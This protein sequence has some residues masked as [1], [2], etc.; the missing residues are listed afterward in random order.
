MV[1]VLHVDEDD[2]D[3]QFIS[4]VTTSIQFLALC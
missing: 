1:V 2:K 4:F 3:V